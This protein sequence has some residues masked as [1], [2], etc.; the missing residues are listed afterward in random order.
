MKLFT[1][2]KTVARAGDG[3]ATP[4]ETLQEISARLDKLERVVTDLK[5]NIDLIPAIVRKLYLD[6][7]ALPA[8]YDLLAERFGYLSQNEEDG[9][10]LA[11]FKRIGA[12]NHRF[13][14]IGCGMNGGNSGFFAQE[15]GWSGL[16]VDAKTASIDKVQ[17]RFRGHPVRVLK[18]RV[19]REGVNAMLEKFGF[20]GELDL[21]SIDI[22]GMDYWLWEAVSACSPRVVA[23]E[24]NWLFG[25]DHAVTIPYASEFDLTA[26][27]NRGYRGASLAAL[28]HL[29]RTKGYRLVATERVNAFFLRNDLA[30]DIREIDVARGYR[31]PLNLTRAKDVFQ[32]IAKAG[33]PLVDVVSGRSAPIADLLPQ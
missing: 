16:M 29:G 18:Q 31:A 2:R 25:A 12:T 22:D 19:T 14:E 21:L 11:L 27:G 8:P 26:I 5:Q 17:V 15:C 9:L 23:I 32:K 4:A 24:Y 33:L 20:T 13:V 1:P 7:V 30:P 10:L 3:D 6:G 28:V